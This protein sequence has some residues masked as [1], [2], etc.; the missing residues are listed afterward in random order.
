MSGK[1]Y[2]E[3]TVAD[4]KIQNESTLY[5]VTHIN[6]GGGTNPSSGPKLSETKPKVSKPKD[7]KA[8]NERK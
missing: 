5:I 6:G 8:S 3:K 2:P 4:C 1:L 7:S